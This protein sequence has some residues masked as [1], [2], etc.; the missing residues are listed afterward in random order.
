MAPQWPCS[1]QKWLNSHQ[2]CPTRDNPIVP[3]CELTQKTDSQEKCNY[4]RTQHEP[5]PNSSFQPCL[6]HLLHCLILLTQLNLHHLLR[7]TLPLFGIAS[8]SEKSSRQA[9]WGLSPNTVFCVRLSQMAVEETE[10][11]RRLSGK[12]KRKRKYTYN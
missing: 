8:L 1:N 7:Q 2:F 3:G 10:T 6:T 5:G 4:N 12:V 9:S 11:K